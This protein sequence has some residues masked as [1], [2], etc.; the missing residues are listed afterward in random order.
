MTSESFAYVKST[1]LLQKYIVGL[2]NHARGLREKATKEEQPFGE[3]KEAKN[4]TPRRLAYADP[5]EE[6]KRIKD[7]PVNKPRTIDPSL[8]MNERHRAIAEMRE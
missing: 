4:S 3:A 5:V 7:K 2:R 6:T 8:T 1:F